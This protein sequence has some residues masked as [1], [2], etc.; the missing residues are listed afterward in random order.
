MLLKLYA[1]LRTRPWPPAEDA[2][3]QIDQQE[4]L[5]TIRDTSLGLHPRG[6]PDDDDITEFTSGTDDDPVRD[7]FKFLNTSGRMRLVGIQVLSKY[8]AYSVTEPSRDSSLRSS[9]C[10]F[11]RLC[12]PDHQHI[13]CLR[14]HQLLAPFC[15]SCGA[16]D[17]CTRPVERRHGFQS[18]MAPAGL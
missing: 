4:S 15:T 1:H 11:R 9:R 8:L 5:P 12:L 16:R 17:Y 7:A 2:N 6:N 3:V 13:I 10:S 14:Y 18:P